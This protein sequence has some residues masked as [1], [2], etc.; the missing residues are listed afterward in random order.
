[1]ST[2]LLIGPV[3]PSGLTWVVNCLLEL[4]VHTSFSRK[5]IWEHVGNRKYRLKTENQNLAR[6]L[7]SLEDLNREFTFREDIKVLWSHD[8]PSP[9]LINERILFFTRDPRTALYSEYKRFENDNSFMNH[10]LE[11]DTQLLCSRIQVWNMFH[12]LWSC[13]PNV[14]YVRFEDYKLNP[15][16]TLKNCIESLG[17][18]G[19]TTRELESAASQSTFEKAKKTES[20]YVKLHPSSEAKI[21]RLGSPSL[22]SKERF[23]LEYDV[24]EKHA[25]EVYRYVNR[26][27]ADVTCAM[28]L[29]PF[30]Y[31]RYSFESQIMQVF[32]EKFANGVDF[33]NSMAVYNRNG[34]CFHDK[35]HLKHYL[36]KYIKTVLGNLKK[37]INLLAKNHDNF[38]ISPIRLVT[39]MMLST[40]FFFWRRLFGSLK[41]G[42]EGVSIDVKKRHKKVKKGSE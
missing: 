37:D 5:E 2:A 25:M 11:L 19:I 40:T 34:S 30:M 14:T 33:L 35:S 29:T 16:P 26:L 38:R 31:L 28:S 1:M 15:I 10:I 4:G 13:Q 18:K 39:E 41:Q 42:R 21:I 27:K 22:E 6:W 3:Q 17:I 12:L 7:P 24:I 32:R 36:N 9:E 23:H 20:N 8:W